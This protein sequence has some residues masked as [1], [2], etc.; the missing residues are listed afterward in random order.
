MHPQVHCVK[1]ADTQY[2]RYAMTHLEL[3]VPGHDIKQSSA[4]LDRSS[5][6][7]DDYRLTLTSEA[8]SSLATVLLVY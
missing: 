8:S 6:I 7:V 3:L 2:L 4:D 5:C 1:V